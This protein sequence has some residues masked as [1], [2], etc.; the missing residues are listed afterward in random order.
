MHCPDP[1]CKDQSREATMK[2]HIDA[3]NPLPRGEPPILLER[4]HNCNECG[5]IHDLEVCPCCGSWIDIGFG[6]A[7]GSFGPYKSCTLCNWFWTDPIQPE[8]D[9]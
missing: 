5:C 2:L 3:Y 8:E 7:F 4:N 6:L 9:M 1:H